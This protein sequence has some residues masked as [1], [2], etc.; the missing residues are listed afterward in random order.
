MK[1]LIIERVQMFKY[2]SLVMDE[3]MKL[4]ASHINKLQRKLKLNIRQFYFVKNVCDE[5]LLLTV[6]Y[7]LL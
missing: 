1:L 3:S 7:I 2:L 6:V 4:E 5:K